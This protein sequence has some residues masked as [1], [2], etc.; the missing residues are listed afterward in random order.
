MVPLVPVYMI[1]L[2]DYVIVLQFH[3][4]W[5]SIRSLVVSHLIALDKCLGVRAIGIGETLCRVIGKAVCMATRLDITCTLVCG[6]DQ[7]CAGLQVGIE[8]AIH[9]INKL[10]YSHQ[11]SG[12]G[13]APC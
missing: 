13:C 9:G 10:F 7:L 11:D 12:L 5:D 1:L 8:E 3:C 6:S 4:P 2:Q